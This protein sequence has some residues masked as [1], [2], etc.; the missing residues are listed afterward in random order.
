MIKPIEKLLDYFGYRAV[1]GQE[2]DKL[3]YLAKH[4]PQSRADLW[5]AKN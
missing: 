3:I 4:K 5:W 1:I 2:Y